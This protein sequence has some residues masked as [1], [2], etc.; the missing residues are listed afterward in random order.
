MEVSSRKREVNP[1]ERQPALML[2]LSNLVFIIVTLQRLYVCWT[3]DFMHR[4]V[5]DNAH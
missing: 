5:S 3:F 2:L 1:L 4:I